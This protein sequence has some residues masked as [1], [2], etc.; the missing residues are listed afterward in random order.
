MENYISYS[1]ELKAVQ[2]YGY[3]ITLINGYE[4][5]KIYMFNKYVQHIIK[6][7]ILV[8]LLKCI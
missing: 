8:L 2:K 1:E 3:K 4:I 7:K 6:R 5:S